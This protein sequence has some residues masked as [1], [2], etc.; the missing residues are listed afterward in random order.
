MA[1]RSTRKEAK[2]AIRAYILEHFESPDA[3]GYNPDEVTTPA[4]PDDIKQ[5]CRAIVEV[6]R[7]E[8]GWAVSRMGEFRALKEW[9]RGLPSI[10]NTLPLCCY[11]EARA[12][13]AGW[14]QETAEEA[15]RYEDTAVVD[16]ALHLVARE[17]FT[18]AD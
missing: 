18:C 9:M 14:L 16:Y 7:L 2:N 11:A 6:F 3:L 13:V 8:Y 15:S 4:N 1:I 10:L 12:L 5:V 17:I